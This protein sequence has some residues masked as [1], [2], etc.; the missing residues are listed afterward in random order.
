MRATG[1]DR[2]GYVLVAVLIVIVVL[3]LVSYRFADAM[4]GEQKV[5]YRNGEAAQAKAFAVSGIH[6]TMG[7]LADPNSLANVLGD[8]PYDNY[9]ALANVTVTADGPRGGGR[10]SI[11]S[12]AEGDGS[13]DGGAYV[14][15]YG[16]AD[17]A[18][19]VNLNTMMRI[20]SSGEALRAMLI[21]LPNMSE[22]VA[23]A[24]TDWLDAD[25]DQRANGAEAAAYST[26][27]PRN[28]AINTLDELL[29]VRGVSVSNLF[30]N[31]R[32]KNGVQDADEADGNAFNRGWA[33]YLTVYGHELNVDS[34][35][36]P[37]LYVN[38]AN[39]ANVN[40]QLA[41]VVGQ[42]LA[43]YTVAYRMYS[44][45]SSTSAPSGNTRVGTAADLRSA[46]QSSLAGGR[47]RRQVRN[48][49]L[50]M[51]NTRVTL[52]RPPN[53][54]MNEPTV[55]V[56][57][58]LNDA[59]YLKTNLATI[60]DKVTA[61]S[62][63]ELNPRINVNTCPP[64]LLSV[65]PGV[66]PEDAAAAISARADLDPASAEYKT[67]AWL[68]TQA[69]MRM[70]IFK[71]IETYITGYTQTYRIQ[72]I[73]YFATGGPVARVEAVIDT[74]GGFPRIVYYRDLTELGGGFDPPRD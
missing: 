27:R 46:V 8:N 18:G 30:G 48:S 17:E 34:A 38:D 58:P 19:K 36:Q 55:V 44:T 16:V 51:V 9:Q 49:M 40:Q 59:N 5:A 2:R 12:V 15:R 25:D 73:G 62:N 52:P 1:R 47:A 69:G 53:T 29:L 43:D 3:S 21:L 63:H 37:R 57:C 66:T 56:N 11:V 35:G 60:L 45:S 72:S 23:D 71:N 10:F 39:M 13:T 4:A 7:L 61:K 65:L 6:Y 67:G 70:E 31:D 33:D 41:A 64:T 32:N 68:H 74:N 50:A 28:G 24:I 22:D 14:T 26:Y 42:E 54:P 20:D